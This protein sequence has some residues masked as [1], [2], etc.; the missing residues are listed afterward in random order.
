VWTV[1]KCALP[2]KPVFH[3]AR[4]K[5]PAK[6]SSPIRSSSS[7]PLS[8]APCVRG[9]DRGARRLADDVWR[10]AGG[11][12]R[13]LRRHAVERRRL[14]AASFEAEAVAALL[15]GGDEEDVRRRHEGVAR[16]GKLI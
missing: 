10:D 12:A 3:P 13:S 4:A 9:Q 16:I 6:P 15:V 5:V 8:Q 2:M 14:D 11:K 1:E 7:M